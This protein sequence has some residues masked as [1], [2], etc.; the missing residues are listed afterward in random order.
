M[1]SVSVPNGEP[2]LG[3]LGTL[4]LREKMSDASSLSNTDELPAR[5]NKVYRRRM[6]AG[7]MY[8]EGDWLEAKRSTISLCRDCLQ[9]FCSACNSPISPPFIPFFSPVYPAPSVH[10]PLI[11]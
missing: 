3:T 6:L 11:L 10:P 1:L 8:V 9:A 4:D 2:G 5:S 7:L